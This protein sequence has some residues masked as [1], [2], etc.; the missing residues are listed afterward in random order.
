[1]ATHKEL[2]AKNP[3]APGE[4]KH[5]L[6]CGWTYPI[7][8]HAPGCIL[9]KTKMS[10]PV[11]NDQEPEPETLPDYPEVPFPKPTTDEIKKED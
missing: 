5:C 7:P 9:A 6:Q 3:E 1:M 8:G 2:E 11:V 4:N 10:E